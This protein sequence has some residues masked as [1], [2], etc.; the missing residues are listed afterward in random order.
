MITWFLPNDRWIWWLEKSTGLTKFKLEKSLYKIFH[1][2]VG[3]DVNVP[4]DDRSKV[5]RK[6]PSL[7]PNY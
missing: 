1:Y 3:R 4:T 6:Y 2:L 5:L 7:L